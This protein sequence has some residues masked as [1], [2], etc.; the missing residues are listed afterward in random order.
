LFILT[1]YQYLITCCAF[2]VAYPFRKGFW[3]NRAFMIS[4]L[5]IFVIDSLFIALPTS[6]ILS[7]FFEVQAFTGDE[8][9]KMNLIIGIVSCSILTFVSEKLIAI[10]FTKVCDQRLEKRKV[11]DFSNRMKQLRYFVGDN[12]MDSVEFKDNS[13]FIIGTDRAAT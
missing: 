11:I 13:W 10:N 5:A 9:Y 8:M 6:S 4:V 12:M 7:R 3:T 2:S 1:N